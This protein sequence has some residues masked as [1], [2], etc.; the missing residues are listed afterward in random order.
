[1]QGNIIFTACNPEHSTP[2]ALEAMLAEI[3]WQLFA[4]FEFPSPPRPETAA[5]KFAALIDTLERELR[6]RVAS[7]Y[8]TE[9]RSRAGAVVPLHFHAA[10]AARRP[11]SPKLV[12]DTWNS[13]IGRANSKGGDLALAVPFSHGLGGIRYIAKHIGEPDCTVDIH[14]VEFFTAAIQS[15]TK[16]DHASL[17]AARRW[18]KQLSSAPM[19]P[20]KLLQTTY[21]ETPAL[22]AR[23]P[24][25]AAGHGVLWQFRGAELHKPVCIPPI[26]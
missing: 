15:V 7:V 8:S 1:M 16:T 3:D 14:N 21:V 11:I 25:R 17:G 20:V 6:T 22:L 18:Q 4:T 19:V 12:T 10:L 9:T 24:R 13:G 5:I 23:N 26:H 2:E